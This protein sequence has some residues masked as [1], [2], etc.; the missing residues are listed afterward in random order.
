MTVELVSIGTELLLGQIVDT[1]A[2]WLSARLAEVGVS[3]YRRT[4]VGDNLERIVAALR[5]ALSRADGVITIGGLGPTDDDLTRE[6]IAQVLNE[7]LVLDE[8]EAARLQAFFAARGREATERQLRQAM[9]PVSAQPL[10]NPNGTAPGLYAEWRGK[11]IFALPGPPNEF[12][13][14]ATDSVLPRL[15]ARTGGRVIRSRVLRLCGIGES[16]AE[17]QLHDLIGSANPTLAP[18]AKLGEVHFRITARADSPADA[19]R[20]IADMER[21]V[22]ARLGA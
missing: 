4:T 12:Q 19:E 7:P 17:A 1:N 20:M 5:E 11:P 2:A 3:V 22:R 21:E 9:R 18:L 14:M 10:P 15:A 6:A 16:D 13:P 8:G